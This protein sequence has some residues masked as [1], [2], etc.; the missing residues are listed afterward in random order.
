MRGV[1]NIGAHFAGEN[2]PAR[3]EIGLLLRFY[4]RKLISCGRMNLLANTPPLRL[5]IVYVKKFSPFFLAPR[6]QKEPKT[7]KKSFASAEA[8]W[9]SAPSPRKLLKKFDQN[10]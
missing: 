8:T 4:E 5:W 2:P 3:E 6:A 1:V 10:F 7:P 9:G